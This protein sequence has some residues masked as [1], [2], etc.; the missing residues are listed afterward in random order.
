MHALNDRVE[1]VLRAARVIAVGEQNDN[2]Q[3]VRVVLRLGVHLERVDRVHDGVVERSGARGRGVESSVTSPRLERID[4]LA[5]WCRR[6][7][8]VQRTSSCLGRIDG[9]EM[10]AANVASVCG[11]AVKFNARRNARRVESGAARRRGSIKQMTRPQLCRKLLNSWADLFDFGKNFRR[12]VAN[13]H[14]Q[15]AS[16][17]R[18]LTIQDMFWQ[19]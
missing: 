2:A 11:R 3:L 4:W 5:T 12:A 19:L 7:S 18:V 10:S 6:C 16:R 17:G 8:F 15:L 1:R 14:A 9:I 13:V